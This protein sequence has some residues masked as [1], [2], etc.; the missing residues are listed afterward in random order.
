MKKIKRKL[1]RLRRGRESAMT[2]GRMVITKV[3]LG[4]MK[5]VRATQMR[6][7]SGR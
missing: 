5:G 6:P 1:G 4:L 7:R 3:T 2:W